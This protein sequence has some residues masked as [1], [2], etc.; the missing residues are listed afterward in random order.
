MTAI[1]LPEADWEGVEPDVEALLDRWLAREGE[2]V[3]AGQ[4]IARVVLVKATLEITAPAN[5]VLARILVQAEQTF[6]RGTV[7]AELREQ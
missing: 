4:A 1:V 6:K 2:H 5:G 7:L 3:S